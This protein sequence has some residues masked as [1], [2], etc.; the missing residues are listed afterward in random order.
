MKLIFEQIKLKAK[1]ERKTILESVQ[2]VDV[3]ICNTITIFT[4]HFISSMKILRCYR[5]SK[6]ENSLQGIVLESHAPGTAI[7]IQFTTQNYRLFI[8]FNLSMDRRV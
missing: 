1:E 4:S 8:D 3:V 6:A 5:F 7:A 2:T